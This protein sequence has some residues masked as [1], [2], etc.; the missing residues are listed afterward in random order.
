[1]TISL[2]L[3]VRKTDKIL[4]SKQSQV[5]CRIFSSQ[6][7]KPVE[8]RYSDTVILPKSNFQARISSKK[9]VEMDQY[10][11]DVRIVLDATILYITWC[12]H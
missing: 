12:I 6:K 10:I 5:L 4:F 11:Q 1:M 3:V 7:E 2:R 9:R 8:K